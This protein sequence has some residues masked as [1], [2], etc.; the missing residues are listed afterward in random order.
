MADVNSNVT[1]KS[2]VYTDG[3]EFEGRDLV[4]LEVNFGN[5]MAAE[6][7]DDYSTAVGGLEIARKALMN[8][9]LT[10]IAEGPLYGTNLKKAFLVSGPAGLATTAFEDGTIATSLEKAIQLAYTA[11]NTAGR[12]TADWSATTVTVK[13]LQL[14]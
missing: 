9:G 7:G 4:F 14:S 12:T 6:T 5:S 11:A 10:L 1:R 13:N 2:F 8:W 3:V